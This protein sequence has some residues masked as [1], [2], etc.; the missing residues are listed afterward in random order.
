MNRNEFSPSLMKSLDDQILPYSFIKMCL[1]LYID[2]DFDLN[3]FML[4][5]IHTPEQILKKYPKTIINVGTDDPLH[6]ANL[7]FG[8]KLK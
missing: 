6:D 5:P 4:S 8:Y 3:N 7:E 1:E 2:A